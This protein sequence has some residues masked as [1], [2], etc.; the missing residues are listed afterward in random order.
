MQPALHPF[1]ALVLIATLNSGSESVQPGQ[2]TSNFFDPQFPYCHYFGHRSRFWTGNRTQSPGGTIEREF[3]GRVWHAVLAHLHD[4]IV[5]DGDSE[6]LL[7]C[8]CDVVVV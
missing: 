1:G 7:T 3:H 2:F 8:D 6:L 4:G 5:L